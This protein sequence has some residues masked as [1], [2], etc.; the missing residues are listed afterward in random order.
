MKTHGIDAVM[1]FAAFLDVG[2]S[3]RDPAKYYLNNVGGVVNVLNAMAANRI[4]A[5]VFSSTCATYGEPTETPITESHPQR[6]INSYGESKLAAARAAA[7]GGRRHVRPVQPRHRPAAIR[8]RR[9]QRRRA[10]DGPHGAVDAGAETR[11]RSG[12]PLRVG[13]Q[14]ARG[15]R[16]DAEVPVA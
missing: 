3:V 7:A 10:R 14:S 13:G 16:M 1:H 4:T 2:E 9:H 15:V 12:R 8:A 6:P 11:G 5:I